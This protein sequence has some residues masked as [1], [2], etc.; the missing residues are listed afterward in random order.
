MLLNFDE[1]AQKR[2]R[3]HTDEGDRVAEA[4]RVAEQVAIISV[5]GLLK[6]PSE[7]GRISAQA[8]QFDDT[9][10]ALSVSQASSQS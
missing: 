9:A 1:G 6:R 4:V 2:T 5:R 8:A 10:V 7:I 3:L